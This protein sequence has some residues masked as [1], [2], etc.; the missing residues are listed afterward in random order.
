MR[1]QPVH[2]FGTHASFM[3]NAVLWVTRALGETIRQRATGQRRGIVFAIYRQTPDAPPRL[4]GIVPVGSVHPYRVSVFVQFVQEKVRRLT[5]HQ[6]HVSSFQSRNLRQNKYAGAIV[7]NGYYLVVS[8]LSDDL[9]DEAIAIVAA[10]KLGLLDLVQAA[11]L[12]SISGN[13]LCET[14]LASMQQGIKLPH[15]ETE[16]FREAA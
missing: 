12:A 9:A 3:R 11:Y 16:C 10:Y 8:G 14:V 15:Y 13:A 1:N 6:G 2:S 5:R 7:A 4:L